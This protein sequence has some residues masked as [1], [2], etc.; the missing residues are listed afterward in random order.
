VWTANALA[1]APEE[2]LGTAAAL[3]LVDGEVAHRRAE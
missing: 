1:D 3:T 2:L